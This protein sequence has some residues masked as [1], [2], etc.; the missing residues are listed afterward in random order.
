MPMDGSRPAPFA[1]LGGL[2]RAPARAF[3][4]NTNVFGVRPLRPRVA[5][6]ARACDDGWMSSRQSPARARAPTTHARPPRGRARDRRRARA[7][8]RG[9]RVGTRAPRR[10]RRRETARALEA[11]L[12]ATRGDEE[13]VC[14]IGRVDGALADV[15]VGKCGESESLVE[16]ASEVFEACARATPPGA[17]FPSR[18]RA[19]GGVALARVGSGARPLTL[20]L[21]M[22]RERGLTRS[23]SGMVGTRRWRS[24]GGSVGRRRCRGRA[25][26]F[27]EKVGGG[28]VWKSEAAP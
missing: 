4:R 25:R 27:F 18:A 21:R 9:T 13:Y 19:A 16:L 3:D 22:V 28:G 15:V 8:R 12:E 6:R 5:R 24:R 11:M 17:S 20:R 26:D 1:P 23:V 7:R 2:Y 10:R 14:A